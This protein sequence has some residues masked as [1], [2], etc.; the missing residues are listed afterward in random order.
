MTNTTAL[1]NMVKTLPL[2]GLLALGLALLPATSIA[3]ERDKHDRHYSKKSAKHHDKGHYKSK[4]HAYKK[5]GKR[6]KGKLGHGIDHHY[7]TRYP[8]RHSN[9]YYKGGHHKPKHDHHYDHRGYGRHYVVNDY[10][11]RNRFI[12]LDNLRFMIGLH[13]DNLDITFRD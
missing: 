6:Y 2:I 4:K 11:P 8:N 7:S 13:T 12:D 3:G 1:K 9:A 5:H 10:Y